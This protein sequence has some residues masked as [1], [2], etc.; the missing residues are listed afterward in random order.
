MADQP[1]LT[2]EE[3]EKLDVINAA[4]RNE[5]TCDQ[6]AKM[7][8]VSSRQIKRLKKAVQVYGA[9]AVIHKLKG[10]QSNHHIDKSL[11]T[12]ALSLI[13]QKYTDF[14]PGFACEKLEEV[15]NI[16]LSD[17]TVR[18]W[19]IEENLW[20]AH[21]QKK[22][23]EYHSW[24][25]RKE[26]FGE[27]EQFD[28]SYHLW[29][30]DRYVDENGFPIEVCLL[31]SIDDAT[32][33]ITKASFAPNEGVVAVFS[34]WKAYILKWGKPVN[35]YLDRFSTYKIN[36]KAAV[37]NSEL[38]TQFGRVMQ[39]LG[40]GLIFANSPQAKG[41]IERLFQTLQDRLVKELRL[42]CINSPDDGNRFLEEVFLPK[43][44]SRFSVEPT[45]GGN[46][47]KQ[48]SGVDRTNFDGTFAVKA[49]RKVNNDF[50]IHFKN[51]W[52][53][54]AEIQTVTVRAKEAIIV[55][56][57]LNES[58]HFSLREHYLNYTILPQRPARAKINPL[59][60]TGHKL[61][62][63]P[64]ANHPWKRSYKLKY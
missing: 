1:I 38:V 62:W 58:L 45:K 22:A 50:T 64:P 52:Y 51:R 4:L 32:G 3:Q 63:K 61:N 21:K 18:L 25:P 56:E 44:N 15:H 57:W 54:L 7:L 16:A 59:I 40:I 5:V 23:G 30:E 20:R 8:H 42:A 55:E 2:A 39:Q 27:L 33:I 31:A 24:R 6:A 36:H 34:F 47:H 53:Q 49:I 12:K 37:D 17:E 35:I 9:E 13:H 43:F 11:K 41:R 28:G 60:L 10:K 29:F 14:K 19:M 46:L 26:Y 48:L